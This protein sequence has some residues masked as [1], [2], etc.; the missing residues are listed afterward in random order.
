MLVEQ[1]N[2]IIKE[3]FYLSYRRILARDK[4]E[5]SFMNKLVSVLIIFFIA[6]LLL[7]CND[8]N[9]FES[10]NEAKLALYEDELISDSDIIGE[11]Q[12]NDEYFVVFERVVSNQRSYGVANFLEQESGKFEWHETSDKVSISSDY[13]ERPIGI[14]FHTK[15]GKKISFRV[16]GYNSKNYESLNKENRIGIEE[17]NEIDEERNIYYALDVET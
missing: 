8:N 1:S 6:S 4:K 9:S 14:I 11:H 15:D 12:V 7:G 3:E 10:L 2:E 17:I 5:V 16:G 13:P